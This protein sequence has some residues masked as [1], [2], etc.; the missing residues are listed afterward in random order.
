MRINLFVK[1]F[2]TL[3]FAFSIVFLLS[4]YISFKQFSPRYIEENIDVVKDAIIDSASAIQSGSDLEDSNLY[5]ISRS[6]T[7]F[8]RIKEDV[9]L[10]DLGPDYLEEDDIIDFVIEIYDNTETLKEGNLRYLINQDNDVYNISYV[11]EYGISDFLIVSTKVQSL[12]NVETVLTEINIQ[13]SIYLF[14]AIVLLSIFISRSVTKPL[15]KINKYAKDISNLD[16]NNS[17]SIKRK[18]EFRDLVSSLNEMTFNLQK[19]YQELNNANLKLSDDI[20]FEREQ[21]VKKKNLIMTINHEIKTPL[22]VMKGMIEGMVDGVGRFKDKDTYLPE[23]LSQIESIESITKDLTYSL[24]LEDKVRPND[25]SNTSIIEENL[26]SLEELA[27]QRMIKI[28]HKIIPAVLTINEELLMILVTNL[29]KNAIVYTESDTV[30]IKTETN[31]DIYT[32]IVKNKGVISDKDIEKIFESFYR[33]DKIQIHKE[34]QG[35]GLFIVKQICEL[36]GYTYKI[37]ND[38][39]FVTAKINMIIKK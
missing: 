5:H 15:K 9:I 20:D 6:E 27:S 1:T 38:N 26:T 30:E 16:F 34:G 32:F 22:A 33:A 21:E 13:Q 18:D 35:L 11:Y 24:M 29:V 8:I 12:S 19:T 37:F 25:K 2:L 23:L 3:L 7:Q 28:K 17:L 4:V 39:G 10:S 31:N 14:V 36:H